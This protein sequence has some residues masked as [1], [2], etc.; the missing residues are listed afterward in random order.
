MRKACVFVLAV[1]LVTG[2]AVPAMAAAVGSPTAP[3]ATPNKT[4]PLPEVVETTADCTFLSIYDADALSEEAR[5]DFIAA[6]ETLEEATPEDMTVKYFFFH[7]EDP[8]HNGPCQDVFDI[9]KFSKVIVKQFID[10]EWVELEVTVNPDGTITIQQ[11]ID[12]PVAIFMIQ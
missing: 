7:I 2:L 11:L 12:G 5:E 10:G 6:Q 8:T 3:V 1:I 9:G 4:A